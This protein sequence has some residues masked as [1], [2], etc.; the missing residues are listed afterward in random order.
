MIL[1][2]NTGWIF[3]I[4]VIARE[5]STNDGKAWKVEG[6][7]TRDGISNTSLIGIASSSAIAQDT[8]AANWDISVTANDTDEALQ[9]EVTG[10]A[11][12]TIRWVAIVNLAEVG[13]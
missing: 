9:I 13:G 11:F 2:A 8:G 1:P 3:T 12:K 5:N 4:F 7:I 10:E 6:A